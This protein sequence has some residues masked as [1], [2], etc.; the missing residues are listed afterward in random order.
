M[1]F[2]LTEPDVDWAAH[3]GGLVAGF[4]G[5]VFLSHDL[6]VEGVRSRPGRSLRVAAVGTVLLLMAFALLPKGVGRFAEAY[7]RYN[8]VKEKAQKVYNQALDNSRSGKLTNE[9]LA[10]LLQNEI[11]P[12]WRRV[13][14]DLKKIN[15]LPG[16]MGPK[17]RLMIQY[18]EVQEE[19]WNLIIRGV[20]EPNPALFRRANALQD[21]ANRL[22]EI[23]SRQD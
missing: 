8:A 14:Q 19:C 2:G 9:E 3:L 11:L 6:K 7:P 22:E 5:G 21:E 15:R 23:I 1:F 10:G 18:L 20:R 4:P 13:K 16:K 12:D 17:S